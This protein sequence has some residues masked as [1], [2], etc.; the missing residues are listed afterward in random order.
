MAEA[1]TPQQQAPAPEPGL[2]AF[3]KEYAKKVFLVAAEKA[4]VP[5]ALNSR[6]LERMAEELYANGII[7]VDARPVLTRVTSVFDGKASGEV[8]CFSKRTA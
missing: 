8:F 6:A 3:D 2:S 5:V 1:S 4:G 7:L